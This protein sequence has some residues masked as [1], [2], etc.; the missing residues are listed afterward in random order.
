M[1]WEAYFTL[2]MMAAV[3]AGLMANMA[4]DAVLIGAVVL[5]AIAG[6]I[7]PSEAFAG[8][9]NTGMLTVAALFIVAAALRETGALD[10][11][12]AWMLGRAR[13]ERSVMVRLSVAVTGMSAFLNNTPIVA[14]FI[15][16]ITSW[17]KKNRVA[18]SRLLIP[19][20]YFSV[21]GGTCT[22]IGTSTNLV[23]NGLMKETV[24]NAP[25]FADTLQ[26]M[27]LFE[28]GA[29]GLPYAL[30]GMAFLLLVGPRLLPER[31]GLLEQLSDSP[32]EY[33]VNLEVQPG[34]RLGGQRVD[35]A[36]L[37]HLPG[38]FLIEITR[39]DQLVAPV[40][41]DQVLQA[42]DVL[43]FT[44]VVATIVD[45]EKIPGLVPVGDRGYESASARKRGRVM[46]EAVVSNTAP[47][48]GKTIRDADFRASYNAAVVAVHRGRERLKAKIGDIVLRPG[49]T[50]L[51]QTG[52]HFARAHRNNPDFLLVSGVEDSRPVRSDKALVS[53]GLL[54]VLIALLASNGVDS[55]IAAF[56]V[57]GLMI[58][59]G[60]IS[61]SDARQSIDF[62][63]LI[64]ICAAF[65]L[66]R[67]LENSH[68][69]SFVSD[70]LVFRM[71]PLGPT[72]VMTTLFLL[73]S[74][75][76]TLVTNNAAAALLFPFAVAIAADMGV[77]PRPLVMAVTLGASACFASPIGYQTNLMV[78]GPGN[79]RFSDFLRVG[80]PLNLVL[81]L[82]TALLVPMVWPF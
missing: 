34:C 4:P 23:I 49:D 47:Y 11:V 51:M 67:A 60:C 28:I 24:A 54:G 32:R 69:V 39:G 16:I 2:G 1:N 25:Q 73:T 43:T 82:V 15:P 64:T 42:G 74:V 57:A 3:F 44:G 6:I 37:R 71:G 68:C 7:T 14:M 65:G 81:A 41:P 21:L 10:T 31:K 30:A 55:A 5:L 45:L 27:G 56:T 52:P 59:T 33:L 80:V 70:A 20:S 75:V 22:L 76:T 78:Y 77:S 63:T 53:L 48:I 29:V 36:G 38:L 40:P 61:V 50:L 26:P 58:V 13:T 79:Y 18:P 17:C 46:C 19:L 12:A 72:V 9:S 62:Q 8:F 66:A 35:E